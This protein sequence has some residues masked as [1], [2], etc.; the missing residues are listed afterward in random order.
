MST[1]PV[2]VIPRAKKTGIAGRRDGW[3]VVRLAAPP[4]DGAAN[5]ALISYL[6]KVLDRPRRSV[7]IVSGARSR[8]KVVAIDGVSESEL[9]TR[10]AAI[11]S[12]P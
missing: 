1:I 11:E 9:A 7:S 10:L 5:E 8:E 3:V 2:R 12:T 4:V 6:A